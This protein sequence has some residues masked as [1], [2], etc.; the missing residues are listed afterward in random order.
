MALKLTY[1]L[2]LGVYIEEV[3]LKFESS[4]SITIYNIGEDTSYLFLK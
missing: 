4:F 3:L 1:I 2:I